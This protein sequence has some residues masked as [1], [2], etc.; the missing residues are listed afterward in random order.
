MPM[1]V[2]IAD[3]SRKTN[4]S[5][6]QYCRLAR[7]E[8]KESRRHRPGRTSAPRAIPCPRLRH[9]RRMKGRNKINRIR[10]EQTARHQE[11]PA[12]RS[13]SGASGFKAI[14]SPQP[15]AEVWFS[16]LNTNLATILSVHVVHFRYRADKAQPWRL[17]GT[18][19]PCPR[20]SRPNWPG[21]R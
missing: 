11:A 19:R 10:V 3:A 13:A 6:P 14:D 18:C 5:S 2:G 7:P 9:E 8:Q 15:Q 17:L 12:W 20:R 1:V 16:Y 4:S 21:R